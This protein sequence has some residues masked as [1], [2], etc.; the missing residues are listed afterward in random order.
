MDALPVLY[1]N[2]GDMIAR[3]DYYCDLFDEARRLANTSDQAD[4][5]EILETGMLFI[6]VTF[7]H[8]EKY[9]NGTPE[10]QA[11]LADRYERLHEL[12]RKHN[13]WISSGITGV[14]S[15]ANIT[16]APE[17]LNLDE[18]PIMW[19]PE[20]DDAIGDLLG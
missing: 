3:F 1:A 12:C 4:R 17:K 18:N 5:I 14:I 10:E 8:S 13:V 15:G 11:L 6:G 20:V 9:I 7:S 19:F 16:Y 2:R